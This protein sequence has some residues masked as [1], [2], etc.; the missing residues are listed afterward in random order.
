MKLIKIHVISLVFFVIIF[1]RIHVVFMATSVSGAR[2]AVTCLKT[3]L[4]FRNRP[5]I[6][7]LFVNAQSYYVLNTLFDTW[8]LPMGK[9]IPGGK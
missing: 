5:L 4:H 1:Q 6:L 7:H 9:N 8:Q 2:E 3:I